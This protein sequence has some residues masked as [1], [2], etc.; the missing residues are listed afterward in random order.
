MKGKETKKHN[1]HSEFKYFMSESARKANSKGEEERNLR[2]N[3]EYPHSWYSSSTEQ[4]FADALP[5]VHPPC[6]FC[7]LGLRE[8][9]EERNE[10]VKMEA[11]VKSNATNQ[12]EENQWVKK[13]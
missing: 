11:K 4:V 5:I 2:V 6:R 9:W 8:K 3:P 13:T 10:L 12:G 7:V 1:R